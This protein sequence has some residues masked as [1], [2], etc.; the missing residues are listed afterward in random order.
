MVSNNLYKK[1]YSS[2]FSN[3]SLFY[4]K[5]R[6]QKMHDNGQ[7]NIKETEKEKKKIKKVKDKKKGE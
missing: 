3:D 5:I 1:K 2:K 7:E 6:K 4:G